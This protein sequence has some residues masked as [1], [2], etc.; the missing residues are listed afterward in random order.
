MFFTLH[1]TVVR[2]LLDCAPTSPQENPLCAIY[3]SN[4]WDAISC[5]PSLK[6]TPVNEKAKSQAVSKMRDITT[7]LSP[8]QLCNPKHVAPIVP[9]K[10][11]HRAFSAVMCFRSCREIAAILFPKLTALSIRRPQ[12]KTTQCRQA[13]TKC[14]SQVSTPHC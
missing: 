6:S 9:L 5:N 2:H 11:R 4:R 14:Y 3:F 12:P 13:V 7:S 1:V 8:T 10:L